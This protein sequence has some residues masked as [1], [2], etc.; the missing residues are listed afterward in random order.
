MAPRARKKPRSN[1]KA[2]G[3][4]SKA[5]FR[6]KLNSPATITQPTVSN[7]TASITTD[8]RPTDLMSRYSSAVTPTQTRAA[9][10]LCWVG[11]MDSQ[12]NPR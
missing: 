4:K 11:D 1:W 10:T 3:G 9:M 8:R 5:C 7:T 6:E 12:K 2:F